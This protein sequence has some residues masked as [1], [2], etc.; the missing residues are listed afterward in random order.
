MSSHDQEKSSRCGLVTG[1]AGGLG[2]EVALQ[3]VRRGCRIAITD[4]N[5]SGLTATLDG[6]HG[7]TGEAFELPCDLTQDGEPERIVDN[8]VSALGGLDFVVNNAAYGVI[9]PYF[10]MSSRVWDR[11]LSLNVVALA[12]ICKQAGQ[13]MRERRSGRI[14]NITSPA[15]RMAIPDYAAYAASKAA[16]DSITR[17]T[18]IALAPYGVRVNA[19]A[20]GMMDTDMQRSTEA[21]LARLAGRSDLDAFLAERTQRVPLGR[22]ASIEE[23]AAAVI[24]LCLDAPEYMTAERLNLSGGLDKD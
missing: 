8:A 12:L 15:S 10:D 24:W 3:L 5:A 7:A 6:L 22:R 18:A 1:A 16:V 2:R 23:I 19:L 13:V 14:I 9:E 21:D 11:T 4:I 17:T 20:P